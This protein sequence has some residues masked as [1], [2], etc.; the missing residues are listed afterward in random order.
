[1]SKNYQIKYNVLLN[2][3]TPA[4][5]AKM[6]KNFDDLAKHQTKVNQQS[7]IAK[8]QL[9]QKFRQEDVAAKESKNKF[10][11][12]ELYKARLSQLLSRKSYME[13]VRQLKLL[14][15]NEEG[16]SKYIAGRDRALAKIRSNVFAD[17]KKQ[18][19]NTLKELAV[20]NLRNRAETMLGQAINSNNRA[21]ER[22]L[23]LQQQMAE[24]AARGQ[25]AAGVTAGAA[26]YTGGSAL[27][28]SLSK[29]MTLEQL[30]IAMR[31]QFGGQEG[32]RVMEEMKKYSLETMF[33]LEDTIQL[34]LDIKKGS[35]NLGLNTT[36]EMIDFTKAVG[37]P[38]LSFATNQHTRSEAGYQL[39]QIFQAGTANERQDIKVIARAGIPIYDNL[40]KMT[41]KTFDELQDIYGAELPASLIAKAMLFMDRSEAN[42]RAMNEYEKSLTI[43]W[44]ATTEQFNYTSAKFGES[45]SKAIKLPSLLKAATSGLK[46]IENMF[47]GESSGNLAA[48]LITV[49]AITAGLISLRGV[50]VAAGLAFKYFTGTALVSKAGIGLLVTNLLKISGIASGIYLVFSNWS[51]LFDSINEKGLSGVLD[52]MDKLIATLS[53][54]GAGF[55]AGGFAGMAVAAAGLGAVGLY[56]GVNIAAENYNDAAWADLRAEM[57][58]RNP[59]MSSAPKNISAGTPSINIQMQTNVDSSG[60]TKSKAVVNN[61]YESP[62]VYEAWGNNFKFSN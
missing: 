56:K 43:A 59:I 20:M 31:A 25:V 36:K 37:R 41:G 13:K 17:P 50:L 12:N 30:Q 45:I 49:T 7:L 21:R 33:R 4:Q 48:Y 46:A 60:K 18:Y 47:S 54:L 1:M 34:L 24:K 58:S 10:T 44:Q 5:L 27:T 62:I 19:D 42:M 23:K 8:R 16:L 40:S 53:V 38:L 35:G 51:A 32:N 15:G 9:L 11:Q 22:A 29:T 39:G 26:L 2:D 57:N 52:H 28:S 14:R 3:M 6:K 61:P 55:A